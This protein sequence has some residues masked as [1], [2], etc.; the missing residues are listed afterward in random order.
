MGHFYASSVIDSSHPL[1]ILGGAEAYA[2]TLLF[3]PG[4]STLDAFKRPFGR[5]QWIGAYSYA[6]LDLGPT[7]APFL[8]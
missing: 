3:D 2:D 4:Y 5:I 6:C 1:T 8:V 7:R